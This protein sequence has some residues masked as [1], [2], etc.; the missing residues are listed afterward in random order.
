MTWTVLSQLLVKETGQKGF[1]FR[2]T[3]SLSQQSI[4]VK[5]SGLSRNRRALNNCL[6]TSVRALLHLRQ[7]VHSKVSPGLAPPSG[8]EGFG[9][10]GNVTY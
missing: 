2:L 5:A 3:N 8:Q 7:G 4:K 10:E 9:L 6:N 1:K